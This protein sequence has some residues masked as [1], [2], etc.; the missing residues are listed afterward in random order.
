[1][2]NRKDENYRFL[3]FDEYQSQLGR[4]GEAST[5]L[6]GNAGLSPPLGRTRAGPKLRRR[7]GRGQD[8]DFSNTRKSSSS[9]RK[10]IY[11]FPHRKGV[12]KNLT[13][14]NRIRGKKRGEVGE[15]PGREGRVCELG[16]RI[17]RNDEEK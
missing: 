10:R 4:G 12:F 16:S 6:K 14:N 9:G 7:G 1:V 11:K 8:G 17:V 15:R 2:R 3:P 13:T 5:R